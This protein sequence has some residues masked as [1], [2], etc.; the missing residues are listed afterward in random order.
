MATIASF[1]PTFFWVAVMRSRYF[2][3]S[4]NF[5]GSVGSMLAHCSC[6]EPSSSSASSRIRA[7]M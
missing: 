4:R 1:W 5:S 7:L 6:A 3:E 2:F